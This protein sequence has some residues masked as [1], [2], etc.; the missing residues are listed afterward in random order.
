MSE[1]GSLLQ[2]QR[3]LVVGAGRSGRSAAAL[4]A[5][6]GAHVTL[7]DER[8]E[9]AAD[10]RWHT[11]VGPLTREDVASAERIV[12]S[13]GLDVDKHPILGPAACD[14]A[15]LEGEIGLAA[16]FLDVPVV[17]IT[18]TNGKSTVTSW[19]G[20]LMQAAMPGTTF[21]GGNLGTPLC[22][23]LLGPRPDRVVVELSSYQLERA[24]T[25]RPS[26][27]TILNLTP[28]HLARHGTMEGYGRAKWRIVANAGPEDLCFVPFADAFLRGLDPGG[29]RRAFL[30]ASPGIVRDGRRATLRWEGVDV[31]LDLSALTL[32]GAHNLD[33]AATSAA[34]AIAAGADPE[35]VQDALVTLRP[36]PHRMQPVHEAGGVLWIDDSKAT[37]VEATSVAVAGLDRAAVVLLGGE[38]KGGGFA[39]LVPDLKRHRAILTFGASREAIAEELR[40][41]GLAGVGV[42]E[43]LQDAVV[44]ARSLARPGDAVLLSPGCASFDAFTDFTHRGRVFAALAREEDP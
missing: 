17:G 26:V 36:L 1:E 29:G 7:W 25:L 9:P 38:A 34:L 30:D 15:V 31:V 43:H 28:D 39:R 19:T 24:G 8:T 27:S 22:E 35:A 33:H 44:A 13:P 11:G 40:A 5:S 32:P 3:V 2:G 6:H 10:A 21:V 20:A 41:A 23:A 37:N 14:G 12:V 18:G 4:A 42:H 16:R